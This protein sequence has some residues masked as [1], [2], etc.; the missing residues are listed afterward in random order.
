MEM[1]KLYC[2]A[3]KRLTAI[4]PSAKVSRPANQL[5]DSASAKNDNGGTVCCFCGRDGKVRSREM[6]I[7]DRL[8]SLTQLSRNPL[9]A[10]LIVLKLKA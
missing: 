1:R 10:N 7:E 5:E 3:Q 6:G 2:F 9:R 4:G 8:L